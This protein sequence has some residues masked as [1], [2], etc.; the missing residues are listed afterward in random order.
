MKHLM[1]LTI[2]CCFMLPKN[3]LAVDFRTLVDFYTG[4]S[5]GDVVLNEDARNRNQA[6]RYRRYSKLEEGENPGVKK[7]ERY[8]YAVNHYLPDLVETETFLHVLVL[9]VFES[10]RRSN[11]EY[12]RYAGFFRISDNSRLGAKHYQFT[13]RKAKLVN[14][15]N[16]TK[17]NDGDQD[18]FTT[19]VGNMITK[20]QSFGHI[21]FK[22]SR[23]ENLSTLHFRENFV[24]PETRIDDNTMVAHMFIKF[25]T[26]RAT[27]SRKMPVF[28]HRVKGIKRVSVSTYSPLREGFV[29]NFVFEPD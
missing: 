4:T 16:A 18:C 5:F 29:H 10:P 21:H 9:I 28:C 19:L 24:V 26:T 12:F 20:F 23:S 15:I 13:G 2:L 3:A 8:C 1:W 27:N 17:C 6:R 14:E 11:L 7:Q 22:I 25:T